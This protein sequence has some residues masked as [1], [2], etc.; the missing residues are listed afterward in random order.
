MFFGVPHSADD[1]EWSFIVLADWHNAEGFAVDPGNKTTTFRRKYDQIQYIKQTYGGDLVVLPGD[2]NNGKW[3]TKAFAK[4]FKPNLTVQQRVLQ[5][6]KNCYGT[7]RKVFREAGYEKILMAVGDHELGGNAWAPNTSKTNAMGKYRAGFVEGFNRDPTTGEDM[8]TKPIGAAPSKPSNTRFKFTSYAHQ[9]KNILFVTV[10]AFYTKRKNFI[11][12]KH[13]LGGEGQIT[14]T[15]VYKHLK[16]FESV[17]SEAKKDSTIKHIIV[18]A[19]LPIIQPVRKV[20]CSGQFMDYGEE[21]E[22]WK[23]MVKYDVDIYLAGEVHT[24]TV[25]RDPESDL[26]QIVSR[27]NSINNFLKVEVTDYSLNVTAYNEIGVKARENNN[28][29]AYGNLMLNKSGVTS[30]S[31]ASI[32]SNALS[33]LPSSSPRSSPSVKP[34]CDHICSSGVLELLDRT[35]ALVHLNFEQIVPLETRQVVGMRH[36][37]KGKI[38]V[39]KRITIRE[40]ECTDSLPNQGSFGQPYDAQVAGIGLALNGTQSYGIFTA[41]TRLG[42]YGTGP[43][44]AGSIISYSV[45]IRTS[46]GSN[47]I[48]VHYGHVFGFGQNKKFTKNIFTLTLEKG[49]PKLYVNANSVLVPEQSYKLNDGKWHDIAVSMPSKSCT[50]SEVVMYIDG[51]IIETGM[52]QNDE[53]IFF[54]TSGRMSLGGFG[55]SHKKFETIFPRL[56]PFTGKMAHFYM[57]GRSIGDSDLKLG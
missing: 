6:G 30:G 25:T 20:S 37:D 39:G 36:D 55:Y 47:M 7:M 14:C 35:S 18:Q 43:H 3:D 52:P 33:N 19:H 2:S 17:L 57:W 31:K 23:T 10:D 4:K 46:R 34:S 29:V 22:F 40:I 45:R 15:V 28:Y 41:K 32:P 42:I 12:R 13:G 9:H 44:G 11:D 38:L 26:L 27:G 54:I 5:A 21:S 48:L 49:T 1:G 50:L 24:N 53:H 56:K 8:F 51:D 16:W